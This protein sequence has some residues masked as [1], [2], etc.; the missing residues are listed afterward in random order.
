MFLFLF[1]DMLLGA[2]KCAICKQKGHK[3]KDCPNKDKGS[4]PKKDTKEVNET[5]STL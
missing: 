1:L 5:S 2:G 3:A 4:T